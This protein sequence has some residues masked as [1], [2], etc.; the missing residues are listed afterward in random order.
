VDLV[1]TSLESDQFSQEISQTDGSAQSREIRQKNVPH[2]RRTL[3][4]ARRC[5]GVASNRQEF[6]SGDYGRDH[7]CTLGPFQAKSRRWW[8]ICLKFSNR[9][10]EK[11][12]H[13]HDH[14]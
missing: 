6:Q 5:S 2:L 9:G 14:E 1:F 3:S 4:Q 13:D 11:A 10:K 12:L 7:V 8:R